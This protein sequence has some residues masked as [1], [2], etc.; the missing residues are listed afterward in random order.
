MWPRERKEGQG[1]PRLEARA[2]GGGNL[3]FRN[4]VINAVGVDILINF[5]V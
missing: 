2:H 4:T 1:E 3:G 5:G